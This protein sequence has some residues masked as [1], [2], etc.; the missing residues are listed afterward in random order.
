MGTTHA[1][2]GFT[3][4]GVVNAMTLKER[5]STSADGP[6]HSHGTSTCI[7]VPLGHFWESP[8]VLTWPRTRPGSGRVAWALSQPLLAL[9]PF[10]LVCCCWTSG[11]LCAP[12]RDQ[13]LAVCATRFGCYWNWEVILMADEAEKAG[14]LQGLNPICVPCA[15]KRIS[16]PAL[17][18]NFRTW[19]ENIALNALP[20]GLV[21]T[22]LSVSITAPFSH[23]P[24][25]QD[26]GLSPR[27]QRQVL[28]SSQ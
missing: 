8:W 12:T 24:P 15:N 19:V 16:P 9:R 13:P 5:N 7:R 4:L 21:E 3:S 28:S 10:G 23:S 6:I 20:E 14:V 22:I 1:S 2:S 18:L 17:V 11:P 26:P 27:Y 25:P